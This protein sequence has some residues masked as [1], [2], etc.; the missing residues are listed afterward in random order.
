MLVGLLVLLLAFIVLPQAMASDVS[1]PPPPPQ[2][3]TPPDPP[4]EPKPPVTPEPPVVCMDVPLTAGW[5][6][7]SW[8]GVPDPSLVSDIV[9]GNPCVLPYFYTWDPINGG[10]VLVSVVR[11]GDGYWVAAT[12]D[13]L[14]R[15]VTYQSTS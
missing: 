11:F 8:P 14:L 3:P 15:C 10:Y 4:G 9:A 6:M 13:C 1:I 12:E 5:N 7:I 2:P